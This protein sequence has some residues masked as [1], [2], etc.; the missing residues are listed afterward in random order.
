MDENTVVHSLYAAP[1]GEAG[2]DGSVSMATG[3]SLASSDGSLM[4][5]QMST[6]K[7][8]GCVFRMYDEEA[9]CS[10]Y[11]QKRS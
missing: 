2:A 10:N 5:T 11:V 1:A 8:R 7:L 9:K 3:G 4:I 6:V